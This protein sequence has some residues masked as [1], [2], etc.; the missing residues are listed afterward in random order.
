MKNPTHWSGNPSAEANEYTYD[1][2][3]D[4][5]DSTTRNYDGVVDSDLAD[6]E[7]QPTEWEDA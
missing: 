3:T 5:Y 4:A 2:S 7:K 6:T 1:S